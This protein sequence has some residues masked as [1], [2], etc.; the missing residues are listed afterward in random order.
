MLRFEHFDGFLRIF[1]SDTESA[2][3][4]NGFRMCQKRWEFD[5]FWMRNRIPSHPYRWWQTDDNDDSRKLPCKVRLKMCCR[6]ALA[7]LLLSFNV[8]SAVSAAWFL[9]SS[10]VLPSPRKTI[11]GSMAMVTI[12]T[13]FPSWT[14]NK[15]YNAN[16]RHTTTSRARTM[17]MQDFYLG[18]RFH[19]PS[20]M[21]SYHEWRL[22]SPH[23]KRIWVNVRFFR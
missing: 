15:R 19:S 7:C 10:A 12:E 5:G 6:Y 11:G 21:M 13:C 4:S 20:R 23:K 8:F 17:Q 16:N 14:G 1:D 3:T 9:A 22:P 2:L 18:W